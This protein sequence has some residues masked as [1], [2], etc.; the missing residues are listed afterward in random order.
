MQYKIIL[1]C[2]LATLFGVSVARQVPY[3][4]SPLN[5]YVSDQNSTKVLKNQ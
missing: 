5:L 2:I 1:V 4:W 3:F